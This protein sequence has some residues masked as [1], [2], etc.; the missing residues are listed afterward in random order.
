[1]TGM[2]EAMPRSPEAWKSM[3]CCVDFPQPWADLMWGLDVDP[4]TA[5]NNVG[6]NHAAHGRCVLSNFCGPFRRFF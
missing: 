1:M 2:T 6:I 5:L 4:E 3:G